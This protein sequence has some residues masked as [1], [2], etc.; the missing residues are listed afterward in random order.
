[1]YHSVIPTQVFVIGGRSSLGFIKEFVFITRTVQ[2]LHSALN[3][4]TY[5]LL[6]SMNVTGNYMPLIVGNAMTFTRRNTRDRDVTD[7]QLHAY[8]CDCAQRTSAGPVAHVGQRARVRQRHLLDRRL[9]RSSSARVGAGRASP[10]ERVR[11]RSSHGDRH[12]HRSCGTHTC[13]VHVE[14]II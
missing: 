9:R 1:M 14:Y 6:I 5:I 8:S 11:H 7:I 3:R 4:N 2:Y 12:A 10:A 13:R